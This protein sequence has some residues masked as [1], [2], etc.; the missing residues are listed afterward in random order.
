M[1]NLA[2]CAVLAYTI[3]TLRK[4]VRRAPCGHF[5]TIS[6]SIRFRGHE[7]VSVSNRVRVNSALVTTVRASRIVSFYWFSNSY[8]PIINSDNFTRTANI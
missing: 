6:F 2:R 7:T 3:A 4:T 5:E 1:V 8:V